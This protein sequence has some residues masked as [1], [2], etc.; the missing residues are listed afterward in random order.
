MKKH[1]AILFGVFALVAAAPALSDQLLTQCTKHDCARMRCDDW[2][3]N[4]SRVGSLERTHGNLAAPMAH[5]VCNEFG[6]CH[7]ALPGFPPVPKQPPAAKPAAPP[8]PA[9]VQTSL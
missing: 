7:Y 4:C 3:E 6:D 5:Q 2:G 9:T 1:L 8:P